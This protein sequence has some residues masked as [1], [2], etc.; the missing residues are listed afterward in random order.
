MRTLLLAI[1]FLQ[2][3]PMPNVP[4]PPVTWSTGTNN[5]ASGT[6]TTSGSTTTFTVVLTTSPG[7]ALVMPWAFYIHS[8]TAPTVSSYGG[9][10]FTDCTSCY[11]HITIIGV[12]TET[13]GIAY[14]SSAVG[15]TSVSYSVTLNTAS[16]NVYAFFA[17]VLPAKKSAGTVSFDNGASAESLCASPCSAP[18]L[19]ITG[20]NDY[21]VQVVATSDYTISSISGSYTSPS[22]IADNTYTYGGT[23]GAKNLTSYVTPAWTWSNTPSHSALGGLCLQ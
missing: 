14:L 11:N 5:S 22:L 18:A 1:L 15:G 10:T 23:A 3:F 17:A 21:C 19:G 4:S 16:G 7:T 2:T 8:P 12:E 13:V 20:T 9:D 6:G